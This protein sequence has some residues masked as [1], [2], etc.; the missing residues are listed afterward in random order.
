MFGGANKSGFG[1]T[2]NTFGSGL[3][4][5]TSKPTSGF[6][7]GG[8]GGQSSGSGLFGNTSATQS[9]AGTLFGTGGTSSSFGTGASNTGFSFGSG[10]NSSTGSSM[11][12]STNTAGSTGLFN[13]PTSSSSFGTGGSLFGGQKSAFGGAS[14]A[15][16]I[17]GQ[18]AA[19]ASPFGQGGSTAGGV[20]FGGGS[21]SGFFGSAAPISGTTK[22]F[23]ATISTDTAVKNGVTQN[24]QTKHQVITAMKEYEN[25]SF[26]ELRVEDYAANRKGPSSG[27]LGTTTTDKGLFGQPATSSSGFG[28]FGTTPKPGGFGTSFGTG[29]NLGTFGQTQTSQQQQGSTLFGQ[30]K[31]FFGGTGTGATTAFGG[32]GGAANT[33]GQPTPAKSLFSQQPPSNPG[34]FGSNTSGFGTGSFG[35]QNT[36]FGQPQST[37]LFGAN[38]SGGFNTA[39]TSAN[40][41]FG[42]GTNN[43]GSSLFGAPKPTGLNLG[44]TNIGTGFNTNTSTGGGLFGGKSNTSF[45]GGFGTGNTGSSLFSGLN[46]P[47]G[48][49]TTFNSGSTGFNAGG[50]GTG[51]GLNL[52]G[53]GLQTGRVI[54]ESTEQQL[55]LL[56]GNTNPTAQQQ[57]QLLTL[58][59]SPY[60]DNPLFKNTLQT[61][62]QREAVLKPTSAAAQKALISSPYKVSTRPSPKI[63][64]KALQARSISMKSQL[65]EGLEEEDAV[66]RSDSFMPRRSVKKL[67]IKKKSPGGSYSGLSFR[68]AEDD[69]VSPLPLFPKDSTSPGGDTSM[70]ES[71]PSQ[72]PG[73]AY[74]SPVVTPVQEVSVVTPAQETTPQDTEDPNCT[75]HH[76]GVR[77][78]RNN[79]NQTADQSSLSDL[80]QSSL[81]VSQEDEN[82]PPPHP[83]GIVLR[84]PGYYCIPPLDQLADIMEETGACMVEDFTIGREGYGSV[85]FPGKTNVQGLNIDEVG[86]SEEDPERL[87][88]IGYEDKLERATM[89][90]GAKFMEY[91]PETG[92]WVFQVEHFSKYGLSDSD[93]DEQDPTVKDPKKLKTTQKPQTKQFAKKSVPPKPQL[94]QQLQTKKPSQTPSMNGE[95]A[96]EEEQMRIDHD[97]SDVKYPEDNTPFR[98]LGGDGLTNERLFSVPPAEPEKVE[99]V[100]EPVTTSDL[101][102]TLGISTHRMQVMKASFFAM[103]D[104]DDDSS[105]RQ[106]DNGINGYDAP[107]SGLFL[108]SPLPKVEE[109]NNDDKGFGYRSRFVKPVQPSSPAK[110]INGQMS[111]SYDTIKEERYKRDSFIPGLFATSKYPVQPLLP[112][113]PQSL[114]IPSGYLPDEKG[115]R[116]VGARRQPMLV[117]LKDSV[118]SGKS[119]YC[120][121]A[122][123]MMGRSFRANFGPNWTLVHSGKPLGQK[124][125]VP[126]VEPVGFG[127]LSGL[128]EQQQMTS[129]PF[130]VSIERVH[131][132]EHL[133]PKDNKILDLHERSLIVQLKNSVR[134]NNSSTCPAFAPEP[135]VTA[136]HEYSKVSAVDLHKNLSKDVGEL[137]HTKSIWDL[138]VALWGRLPDVDENEED[139]T[140][141][142]YA[143]Q[144]ARRRAVTQWFVS[145]VSKQVRKEVQDYKYQ[146]N[147]N[148]RG[149]LALLSGGLVA[150]ASKLAQEAGEHRLAMLTSQAEGCE[151]TKQLITEQLKYWN[152]VKADCYISKEHLSVYA[153]LG[154][155]LVW[156]SSVGVINTCEEMD[157]KRALAIH[158]WYYC[159]P[160]AS[161]SEAL[162]EYEKGVKG[163]TDLGHYC[164]PPRP[165]YIEDKHSY[166]VDNTEDCE[167]LVTDTCYHLLKIYSIKSHRMDSTLAP[168]SYTC[169]PMD[170]RL[171]WHLSQVLEALHYSHISQQDMC[172]L[173]TSYAA[174]LEALGLWHW[175]VF[176]LLHIPSDRRREL[177][178]K[179]LL[180]R[181][182]TLKRSEET[183][184]KERFLLEELQVPA[185]WLHEAKALRA[186]YEG[187]HHD[188]AYHLLKAGCWNEC[189]KIVMC[190]LAADAFIDENF[191]YLK[192]FLCEL[193]PDDR[194]SSIQDWSTNGLVFLDFILILE[195]LHELQ[196]GGGSAFDLEK[197]HPQL[198]SLC[199]RVVSLQCRSAKDRLCRSEMS[200]K[201]AN[202]MKVVLRLQNESTD[203]SDRIPSRLLAHHVGKL[204]MPE[205]YGLEEQRL[206]ARSYMLELT[207]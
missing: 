62:G 39:T 72:L 170:Y 181:Q 196:H 83:A 19:T 111:P 6:G 180:C 79:N 106:M 155:Q 198:A 71:S 68:K 176:V 190:Q 109:P 127:Y 94:K 7:T 33:F 89:K 139:M 17:F 158:L 16:G 162:A 199:S 114:R 54:V 46:K 40:T 52:G 141:D 26:E 34:L 67:V 175:A 146:E 31:Q 107:K 110:F 80:D 142:G 161:I 28:G 86:S 32:G 35:S 185:R 55:L 53:G 37:G 191:T 14:A 73:R 50:L 207:A 143:R 153:M 187:R 140:P 41:P 20:L 148:V 125:K 202:M 147:G 95:P 23:Q 1:T 43:P 205:D 60:G 137:E 44:N 184:R 93:E 122:S 113:L 64:P 105:G 103:D 171:S 2:G 133:K 85:F 164:N 118:V 136:L 84:R 165:S 77:S 131:V 192:E 186:K 154:G 126:K 9:S 194:S 174:Q 63:R 169:Y 59:T 177:S 188:H 144:K 24:Q 168:T 193:S 123:L 5:S 112:P 101:A 30:N 135:G 4:N 157:W 116:L 179:K 160:T 121:D 197:L 58:I 145:A 78:S 97:D 172:T 74:N 56:S 90:L 189:H 173:H 82:T 99:E 102:N 134:S 61:T 100:L 195:K 91:R 57:A 129:S 48:L 204:P 21:S 150:E 3:F 201:L 25:K 152:Q 115:P 183:S 151:R 163:N 108:H 76:L 203:D 12:G 8:F 81:L 69:L 10:S 65:F 11:F 124:V 22:P 166:V 87:S 66:I 38:K 167:D 104:D 27:G 138:C 200:K 29:Q 119:N 51:G 117:P 159:A 88:T 182:C 128:S 75:I 45:G 47:T 13:T 96:V 206:L 132:G 120:S 149:V 18:P 156:P 130:S 49:G 42:F 15:G 98:G 36:G 92:S 70:S 178:V